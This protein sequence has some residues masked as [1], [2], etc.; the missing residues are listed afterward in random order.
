MPLEIVPDSTSVEPAAADKMLYK[1]F[2]VFASL[3]LKVMLPDHVL[4][5]P[6]LSKVPGVVLKVGVPWKKLP[7]M[8]N[9]IV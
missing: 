9:G 2:P 7:F 6:L 1:L 5:P 3:L 8:T 4:T